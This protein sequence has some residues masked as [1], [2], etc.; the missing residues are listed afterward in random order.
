MGKKERRVQKTEERKRQ[1]IEGQQQ[2]SIEE[3]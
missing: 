3:S 1:A 2:W